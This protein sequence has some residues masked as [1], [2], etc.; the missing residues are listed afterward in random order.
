MSKK[1]QDNGNN[2]IRLDLLL[3]LTI[4][5]QVMFLIALLLVLDFVGWCLSSCLHQSFRD[6]QDKVAGCW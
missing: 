3:I 4:G 5:I 1:T 2:N 6:C